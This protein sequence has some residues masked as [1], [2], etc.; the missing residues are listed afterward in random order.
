MGED[1]LKGVKISGF[2]FFLGLLCFRITRQS[3]R[4]DGA[5]IPSPGLKKESQNLSKILLPQWSSL[6]LFLLLNIKVEPKGIIKNKYMNCV[7]PQSLN[8]KLY[9]DQKWIKLI[10]CISFRTLG[11]RIKFDFCCIEFNYVLTLVDRSKLC[12]LLSCQNN[13]FLTSV[14]KTKLLHFYSDATNNFLE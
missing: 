6:C 11:P 2:V 3:D 1:S 9:K 4:S 7:F 14:L 8:V 13:H 10:V 12:F 5:L